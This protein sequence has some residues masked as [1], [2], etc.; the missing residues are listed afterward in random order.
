MPVFCNQT[1]DTTKLGG[2][3]SVSGEAQEVTPLNHRIN[4][5][6]NDSTTSSSSELSHHGRRAS[7]PAK[8]RSF[9]ARREGATTPAMATAEVVPAIAA[10]PVSSRHAGWKRTAMNMGAM[11]AATAIVATLALPGTTLQPAANA[12]SNQTAE[13]VAELRATS[14]QEIELTAAE[15][16]IVDASRAEFSA[17]DP[18]AL[19]RAELTAQRLAAR[20][21]WSGPSV[22]DFLANPPYPNFS[23]DQVVQ[24]ALQY[25]GV[26]WVFGGTTPAGFDCSGFVQYVYAQFGIALPRTVSQQG[27]A[28]T[29]ISRADARPGDVV[30]MPGHN[31]IYMGNGTFIDSPRAGAVISVRPIWSDNYYIVRYGI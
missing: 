22:G 21:A 17:T 7:A 31:G 26:P 6:S 23:L 9:F 27:A 16:V 14:S 13:A 30:I 18:A 11:T 19:R 15:P 24:V 3:P 12:E 1:V 5:E 25:Q 10:V 4:P 28:G 2:P 8:K 29:R 20:A